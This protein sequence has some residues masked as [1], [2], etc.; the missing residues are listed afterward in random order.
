MA[1]GQTLVWAPIPGAMP[2]ATV[3]VDLRPRGRTVWSAR[4]LP[5]A[6]D[7]PKLYL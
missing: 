2:Q 7:I 5:H 3:F 4:S 1:S 6:F